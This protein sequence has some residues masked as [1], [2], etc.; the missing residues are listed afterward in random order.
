MRETT[1]T[2]IR[3]S[4]HVEDERLEAL[5]SFVRSL[6]RARGHA[7]P[8]ALEDIGRAG[9]S[10]EQILE[11]IMGI[12]LK[13]FSNYVDSTMKTPLGEQFEPGAWPNPEEAASRA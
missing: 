4:N 3:S 5:Q 13:T 1:I 11:V 10:R 2:A 8:Q 6:I 7:T 12:T 9:C